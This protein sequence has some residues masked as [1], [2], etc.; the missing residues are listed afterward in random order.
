MKN[1]IK[2]GLITGAAGSIGSSIAKLLANQLD[3]LVLVDIN[4]RK[5]QKL[6]EKLNIQTCKVLSYKCDV[7]D[8]HSVSRMLRDAESMIGIPNILI[9]NAGIGGPF[10]RIDEVTDEEWYSVIN[11]NLKGVF[12]LTRILLPHMKQRSFGKVVNIASVQGYLGASLSSTY[13]A[14]KHGII[15]YTRAI[16]AE[17]GAYGVTCNA[18]CPGYVDTLMGIQG[19]K[20]QN[21]YKKVI[22]KTPLGRIATPEEVANLVSYL[23]K[24]ESNF[25]SGSVITIDGGLTC[26]IGF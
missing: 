13:V 1:N 23:I 6:I 5:M 21:H 4:E 18:I 12:N 8:S 3:G 16:A 24:D 10:H 2:I 14:S 7:G 17:W 20:I 25:I 11:T 15:G 19:D 26:H 9:N 22:E